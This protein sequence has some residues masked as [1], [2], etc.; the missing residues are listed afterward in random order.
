MVVEGLQEN[1][2]GNVGGGCVCSHLLSVVRVHQMIGCGP[3][4]FCEVL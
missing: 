1:E 2:R 4:I 3:T